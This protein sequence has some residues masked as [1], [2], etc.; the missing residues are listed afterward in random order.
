MHGKKPKHQKT[1]EI[2]LYLLNGLHYSIFTALSIQ[3]SSALPED[4]LELILT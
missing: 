1:T 2:T 3:Q 4:N